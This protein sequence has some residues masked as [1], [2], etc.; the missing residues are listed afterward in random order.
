MTGNLRFVYTGFGTAVQANEIWA[1]MR[2]KGK[3]Y[4][5]FL[6]KAKKD[7]TWVNWTAG[8]AAKSILLLNNGYVISCAYSV[9]TMYERIRRATEENKPV[10]LSTEHRFET[11]ARRHSD[12]LTFEQDDYEASADDSYEGD[13]E[14][15]EI[16]DDYEGDEEDDEDEV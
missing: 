6:E 4:K 10:D 12:G 3:V 1:L 11:E 7:G 15:T 8:R 16:D 14:G 13:E 5:T 2:T 9:K